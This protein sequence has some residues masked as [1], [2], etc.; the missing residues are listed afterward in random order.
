M[1]A[2]PLA[3]TIVL[4]GLSLLV[5]ACQGQVKV[6]LDN[7]IGLATYDNLGLIEQKPIGI[8][9]VVGD[10][11]RNAVT[12]VVVPA[13]VN[14]IRYT[15]PVGEALTTRLVTV[16][17]FQFQRVQLLKEPVLPS[18]GSLDAMMIVKI[19]DLD[20]TVKI[21]PKYNT[22]ATESS[23]WIEVE[24]VLKDRA[25]NIVWIGTSRTESEATQESVLVVGSQDAG[26]AVNQAIEKTVAKLVSQMAAS[27]SLRDFIARSG[28]VS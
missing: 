14:S 13:G 21:S 8:G 7:S 15:M 22:V 27:S 11:V 16:L 19:K 26:V 24:A 4:A 2:T 6:K 23:G 17:V 9:L 18:D 25:G 12:E 28:R 1:M 3:R 5:V 20:A 10:D